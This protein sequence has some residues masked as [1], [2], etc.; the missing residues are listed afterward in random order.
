M[1][2][3][4][5]GMSMPEKGCDHCFLREGNL[6]ARLSDSESVV[7]YAQ[8]EQRHPNCPLR[9]TSNTAS[10]IPLYRTHAISE[11]VKLLGAVNIETIANQMKADNLNRWLCEARNELFHNI[12]ELLGHD[13][14]RY[15]LELRW[16][17]IIGEPYSGT[18][19]KE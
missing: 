9:E 13:E 4:I 16:G 12:Q 18:E 8:K 15:L 6:C 19:G 17:H 2:V 7:E 5:K 14:V 10:G 3:T 11:I 1:S